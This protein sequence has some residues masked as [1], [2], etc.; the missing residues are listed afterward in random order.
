[1]NQ[2]EAYPP[3]YDYVDDVAQLLVTQEPPLS[4]RTLYYVL[5]VEFKSVSIDH[6]SE[7]QPSTG[8]V[9]FKM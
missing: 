9:L 8:T 5:V 1:M 6:S 3:C 7:Y 2:V 4:Q